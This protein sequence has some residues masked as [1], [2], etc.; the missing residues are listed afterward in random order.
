MGKLLVDAVRCKGHGICALI[1]PRLIDLDDWGFPVL[2]ASPDYDPEQSK[3]AKRAVA[4]C[5]EQ[6]L[7]L[8]TEVGP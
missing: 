6:A 5:P 8:V 2:L 1:A 4:A 3:L 7:R